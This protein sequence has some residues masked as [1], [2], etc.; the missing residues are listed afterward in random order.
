[1]N[2]L[3]VPSELGNEVEDGG[4]NVKLSKLYKMRH[5]PY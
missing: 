5:R 3:I 2:I 4:E 1:M